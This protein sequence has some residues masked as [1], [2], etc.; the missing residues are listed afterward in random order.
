MTIYAR[1]HTNIAL[2]KYWGKAD[3][4]LMLPAT[5]SIS[6]TLNDFYTDTAVTFDAT[7]S[8]DQFILNDQPQSPIAVSR[9]LD[10]V[11]KLADIKARARVISLNHV[12]TAAGLASSASAFAALALAASRA[13]GLNLSPIDLSRLARRGSGSATRSI[14]GGAVIWHRGFDDASSFAE[15]LAIQPTLPLRML[16]VTVSDQKKAVSSRTGMANTAATSPYYQAWVQANEALISPMITA[17]AEDD[18]ATIGALTELSSMRMHAAI[19][20]EEP[21]FTYFLPETLRAWQ[22]VQEQRRLGIPA[23]VTMDAGP[24][25]KILTTAPYVDVLMTA[26]R[27]AFGDRILSTQLGPD[28]QVIT[29]EQFDDTE[30]AFTSQG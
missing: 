10:H 30:S 20:A 19:M 4:Q 25:V 23:F 11:R 28:A 12:P 22:L 27:P 6:L 9:F 15:P 17:L 8:E 7:L 1:A 24:N 18:F 13:A 14:F 16:V 5:S 2:I 21:P 29:K 26:L 3:K